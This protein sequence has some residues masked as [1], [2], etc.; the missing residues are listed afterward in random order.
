MLGLLIKR[1]LWLNPFLPAKPV[2]MRRFVTK[3]GESW[4]WCRTGDMRMR[5]EGQKGLERL[6]TTVQLC[7]G[8][9]AKG[10]AQSN[11]GKKI[12]E[13]QESLQ[14]WQCWRWEYFSSLQPSGYRQHVYS[15]GLQST[16]G[17]QILQLFPFFTSYA[18][19]QEENTPEEMLG[20][21]T[22]RH[23]AQQGWLKKIP[24]KPKQTKNLFY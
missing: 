20:I 2:S 17:A 12:R 18:P 1:I 21:Q 13:K 23:I 22:F 24:N 6:E 14:Y 9:L 15:W 3:C 19:S 16:Q 10:V 11:Q 5:C 7:M 4:N 8:H